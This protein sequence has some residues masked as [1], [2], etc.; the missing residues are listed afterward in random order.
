MT[1]IL[2]ALVSIGIFMQ[3]FFLI[4]QNLKITDILAKI[5]KNIGAPSIFPSTIKLNDDSKNKKP[6]GP[7]S[8]QEIIAR[9]ERHRQKLSISAKKR[10]QEKRAQK[11]HQSAPTTI[12]QKQDS[13]TASK[14]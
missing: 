12:I 10:W 3:L 1:V 9:K 7:L 8:P 6:K 4:N 13:Q 11:V 2:I 14:I 5:N